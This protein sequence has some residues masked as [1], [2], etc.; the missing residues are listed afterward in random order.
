ML[1]VKCLAKKTCEVIKKMPVKL[2]KTLISYNSQIFP[3]QNFLGTNCFL[4]G[5][6]PKLLMVDTGSL[7]SYDRTFIKRLN[8]YLDS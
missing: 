8:D 5:S 7:P 2:I 4:I 6:G 3:S 1:S